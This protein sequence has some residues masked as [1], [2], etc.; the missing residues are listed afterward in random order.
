M[1][2]ASLIASAALQLGGPPAPHDTPRREG[3]AVEWAHG[4][5]LPVTL[6]DERA[7]VQRAFDLG[8]AQVLAGAYLDA[9]RSFRVVLREDPDCAM[10]LW[11]LALANRHQPARAAWYA[12]AAWLGR[13]LAGAMEREVIDGL[14]AAWGVKGPEERAGLVEP[15]S[16]DP[17]EEDAARAGQWPELGPAGARRWSE[18]LAVAIARHGGRPALVALLVDHELRSAAR[19]WLEL[20]AG[21][22]AAA[23]AERLRT[24]PCPWPAADLP[25][26]PP[27]G[28]AAWAERLTRSL[29]RDMAHAS[30]NWMH[31]TDVPGW[32]ERSRAL[33][34]ALA[35]AGDVE[36]LR[37]HRRFLG[38]LPR[39]PPWTAI[40]PAAPE[41]PVSRSAS[42]AGSLPALTWTPPQAPDFSLLDAYGEEHSLADHRSDPVLVVHFL[43]LGC[44]HCVEQLQALLPF[45]DAFAEAGIEILAIG[46]QEPEVVLESLGPKGSDRGYPFPLLCDPELETFRAWRAFDDFAEIP[47]HGTYLVD[48]G[49][50]VLWIDISHLPFMEVEGL[51][52]ESKRLLALGR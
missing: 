10:A 26:G 41:E 50:R 9:E 12:R 14:A 18:A 39:R 47:L 29:T 19:G 46:L 45:T 30:R 40:A 33:E 44:V 27:T 16:P 52:A 49:G 4:V 42:S 28:P 2:V 43:G 13:G 35:A 24:P 15:R 23:L 5:H 37:R 34:E 25:W 36:A 7:D 32:I 1:L 8:L 20:E 22:E 17:G 48:G 3:A 38:L 51:L 31:P 21:A 11:G 6:T